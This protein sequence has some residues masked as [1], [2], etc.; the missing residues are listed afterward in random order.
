MRWTRRHEPIAAALTGKP[1]LPELQDPADGD[2]IPMRLQNPTPTGIAVPARGFSFHRSGGRQAARNP[3][4]YEIL[5][6]GDAALS[7]FDRPRKL[8]ALHEAVEG[9]NREPRPTPYIGEAQEARR[10][11]HGISP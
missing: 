2:R 10:G 4:I 9:G 8:P 7:E 11:S 6:P 3:V 1:G 5:R